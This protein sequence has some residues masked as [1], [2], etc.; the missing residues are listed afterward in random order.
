VE[1]HLASRRNEQRGEQGG[2]G[3]TFPSEGYALLV[4]RKFGGSSGD[5]VGGDPSGDGRGQVRGD[6]RDP[7]YTG[8]GGRGEG[9]QAPY[10]AQWRDTWLTL[11]VEVVRVRRR[12]G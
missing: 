3:A 11:L 10:L 6:P 2:S 1:A 4:G 8:Y 5:G 7:S 9:D 12:H